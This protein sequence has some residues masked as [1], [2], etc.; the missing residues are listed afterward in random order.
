MLCVGVP[1]YRQSLH[2]VLLFVHQ[3]PEWRL[4]TGAS[5]TRLAFMCSVCMICCVNVC[6]CECLNAWGSVCV[7]LYVA[8]SERGCI[9]AFGV[10]VCLFCLLGCLLLKPVLKRMLIPMQRTLSIALMVG[11]G[12]G[13]HRRPRRSSS[14][15]VNEVINSLDSQQ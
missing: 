2:C 12:V 1:K 4:W 9:V 15:Q 10:C 6:V 13:A 8:A 11:V 7:Q 14:V 3:S 5:K